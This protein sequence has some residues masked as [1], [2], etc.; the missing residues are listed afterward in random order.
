LNRDVIE[1]H[2][3]PTLDFRTGES[4]GRVYSR[5]KVIDMISSSRAADNRWVGVELASLT[6]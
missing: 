6:C 5:A 1:A 3:V 2:R 4:T